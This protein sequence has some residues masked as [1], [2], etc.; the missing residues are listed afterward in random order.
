M[1][2]PKVARTHFHED[3]LILNSQQPEGSN[4]IKT[5]SSELALAIGLTIIDKISGS[6]EYYNVPNQSLKQMEDFTATKLAQSE[7]RRKDVIPRGTATKKL[8][9]SD[10]KEI[11]SEEYEKEKIIIATVEKKLK[12][13]IKIAADKKIK[14]TFN[15]EQKNYVKGL[16]D[17][18]IEDMRL[19]QSQLDELQLRFDGCEDVIE[20]MT[21]ENQQLKEDKDEINMML[22]NS[23]LNRIT[24]LDDTWHA[25]NPEMCQHLFGFHTIAEYR[26]YLKCFWPDLNQSL[27]RIGINSKKTTSEDQRN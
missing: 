14:K 5:I 16:E 3:V 13:K 7:A 22:N 11:R 4:F 1:S 6:S 9:F 18:H 27:N 17:D 26:C 15:R 10:K 12:I 2:R 25:N 21:E 8:S 23:G 24:I 20:K 19:L